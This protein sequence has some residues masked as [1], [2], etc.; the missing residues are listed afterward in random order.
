MGAERA[1]NP[2]QQLDVPYMKDAFSSDCQPKQIL[3]DIYVELTVGSQTKKSKTISD[4]NNPVYNEYLMTA[5]AQDLTGTI[6]IVIK[7]Y[8]PIGGDDKI[9]ECTDQFYFTELEAGMSTIYYCGTSTDLK[10]IKFTFIPE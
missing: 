2:G 5:T 7:D 3:C 6:K 10:K 9:T 4:T 8:D 1:R